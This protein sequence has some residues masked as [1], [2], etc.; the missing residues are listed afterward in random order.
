MTKT[1]PMLSRNPEGPCILKPKSRLGN[2]Y[3]ACGSLYFEPKRRLSEGQS[4]VLVLEQEQAMW[5]P[6]AFLTCLIFNN[7]LKQRCHM[8][9][10]MYIDCSK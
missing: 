4:R 8:Q 2:F 5:V 10:Y 1:C 3:E 6:V 9:V 7:D